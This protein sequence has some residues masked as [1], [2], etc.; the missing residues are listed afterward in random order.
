MSPAL[1]LA[2]AATPSADPAAELS[3]PPGFVVKAVADNALASDSYTMT[4]DDAG[5]VLV[6]GRGY[7]RV[8]VDENG[9]G[10]ADRAIDL[11]DGLKG[12]PMGLFAEGDSLYVVVDGGLKRYR[13]YDGESKLKQPP[14]TLLAIKTTGEHDAHAVR[15]G[16]DGWLYL[17]CGNMAGVTKDTIT[18]PRSPVKDPVAGTLLRISPDRTTFWGTR[19]P[20]EVEVVADGFRNAYSFDFNTDGEPFTYDSDNERC[21]GLPWYEPCRFYHVVPGGNYGWRSPQLGQFWRKPPYFVDCVPP[22]CYLGRGS[23]TGV[24]CYRHTHFPEKYRG[25]FFLADWT[26]GRIHFVPLTPKHSTYEGK[27]EVFAEAIGTSGFAPTALAVHPTT[28]ELYVTIGGRG[29]RGGVY[30]IAHE[31]SAPGEPI[32]MAKRT[33]EWDKDAA[34]RWLAD[35]TSPNARTRRTALELILRWREKGFDWN[36]LAKSVPPSW[37]HEDALLRIAAARTGAAFAIPSRLAETDQARLALALEA[38]HRDPDWA[39][40]LAQRTLENSRASEHHLQAIRI[41]QLAL[42]DLTAPGTEGTVWEGYTLRN[43]QRYDPS[44][45]LLAALGKLAPSKDGKVVREA[46]RTLGAFGEKGMVSFLSRRAYD[47]HRVEESIHYL[48]VLARVADGQ[49]WFDTEVWRV[50][51]LLI[52]FEERTERQRTPRDSFWPLRIEEILRALGEKTLLDTAAREIAFAPAIVK[53]PKFGRPEH[54]MLVNTLKLP[55]NEATKKFIITASTDR[56]FTWTPGLIELLGDSSLD[57]AEPIILKLWEQPGL[58]DAIVRVLAR[59]P[60]SDHQSKY[61]A[62]LQA[63]D[64]E[65]VESSAYALSKLP[66]AK[67]AELIAGVKA[68]RRLAPED[69][70][71]RAAVVALLQKRTEQKIGDDAK[72]WAEWVAKNHP[73][74]AKL[75]ATNDGFDAAAWKK[76]AAGIP[77][78]R[79]DAVRGKAVFA[80]ATC[81]ACHDSGRALGPPLLGVSKRFGRDDLLTSILQ[82][83]KDVSA[84]YRPVR[85]TTTDEKLFIGM[86]VY[87][88]TDGVIL[89]TNT[90]TAVRIAG[91]TI[92]S[93]RPVDASL[94]PA[95]LLDKLTDAEIADLFAHLKSLD[96]KPPPGGDKR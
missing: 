68:L 57:V 75:L 12:G 27:P 76:R 7:V 52:E 18:S 60:D 31:K 38:V 82:P 92:A 11:I 23:P 41:V 28:G 67:Q 74:A 44:P 58:Q 80:K 79:G 51:D 69:K 5:R 50:A 1:L 71:A 96:E 86:I 94:M 16:P 95:G 29:T 13:G 37:G 83:N 70:A 53:H 42:G 73:E 39:L 36:A 17:L 89:Q 33:L 81:A 91:D 87:E 46:A 40:E 30:R 10:V 4:I 47:E 9:D 63:F 34:K 24:A 8:L 65:V 85:V 66:R 19:V 35:C 32:P 20:H 45:A 6:A 3:V 55:R 78:D 2:L 59:K 54:L 77:W 26:F 90:D 72:A 22:V 15:R 25:G 88:A 84:R 49:R 64:P 48:A 62:G 14:E 21:V 61:L 43:P 93:K 56:N